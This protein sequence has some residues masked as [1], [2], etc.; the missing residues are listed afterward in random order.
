MTMRRRSKRNTRRE[1]GNGGEQRKYK[2]KAGVGCSFQRRSSLPHRSMLRTLPNWRA[3]AYRLAQCLTS[4]IFICSSQVTSL[5]TPSLSLT[6]TRCLPLHHVSLVQHT[7]CT[8]LQHCSGLCRMA[9]CQPTCSSGSSS[10]RGSAGSRCSQ[11]SQAS[12]ASIAR[13]TRLSG[14][15]LP[16]HDQD[17]PFEYDRNRRHQS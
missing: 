16:A 11:C 3:A 1:R 8:T 10:T 17:R 14:H 13:Q 7:R 15:R 9:P 2:H 4:L 6:S 5:V 12:D